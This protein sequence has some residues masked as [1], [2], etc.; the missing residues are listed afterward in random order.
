MHHGCSLI[1]LLVTLRRPKG[2]RQSTCRSEWQP[3]MN[4]SNA[5]WEGSPI[6]IVPTPEY[7]P[8]QLVNRILLEYLRIPLLSLTVLLGACATLWIML[9]PLLTCCHCRIAERLRVIRPR[10]KL[11]LQSISRARRLWR[12]LGQRLRHYKHVATATARG[13]INS[14]RKWASRTR[15]YTFAWMQ[16]WLRQLCIENT[17]PR[18]FWVDL[19]FN[20]QDDFDMSA[21]RFLQQ[22]GLKPTFLS[23]LVDMM[24]H[25][26]K[27]GLME[28]SV[29]IIDLL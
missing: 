20:D 24:R 6:H 19:K 25:M 5:Y 1:H 8:Q 17:C 12:K 27:G 28:Q 26:V 11:R 3:R 15:G 10:L 22:H 29:D 7:L 21:S 13:A 9:V 23:G 4:F 2:D 18:R 16:S 14:E